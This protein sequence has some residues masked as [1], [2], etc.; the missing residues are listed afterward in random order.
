MKKSTELV[1]IFSQVQDRRSYINKLH[2]IV[3]I[4][5]IGIVTFFV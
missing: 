2:D 5:L 3:G 4:L 1:R